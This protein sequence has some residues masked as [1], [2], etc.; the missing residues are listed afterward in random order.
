MLRDIK[1][2]E[3]GFVRTVKVLS[4]PEENAEDSHRGRLL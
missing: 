3:L 1:R 2:H 4:L